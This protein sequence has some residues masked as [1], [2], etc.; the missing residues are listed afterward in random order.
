M[1]KLEFRLAFLWLFSAIFVLSENIVE[2][3][4]NDLNMEA[5]FTDLWGYKGK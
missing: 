3:C 5:E 2:H 1:L 4:A